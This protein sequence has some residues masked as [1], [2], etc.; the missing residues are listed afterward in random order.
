M[1]MCV[2]RGS[3]YTSNIYAES[4]TYRDTLRV[5]LAS[6]LLYFWSCDSS[7]GSSSDGKVC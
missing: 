7:A 1:S 5:T 2:M 4:H 6:P 3:S